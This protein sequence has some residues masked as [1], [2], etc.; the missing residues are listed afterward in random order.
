M[1][2]YPIGD[3][4]TGAEL[5]KLG[6]PPESDSPAAR[7]H[8]SVRRGARRYQVMAVRTI[9]LKPLKGEWYLSGALPR[10][11]RAPNDLGVLHVGA[12]LVLTETI[13][14]SVTKEIKFKLFAD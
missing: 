7:F 5:K 10:A 13:T 1:K 9:K 4:L 12:K 2:F 14:T 11:Y 3:D 8:G 6:V